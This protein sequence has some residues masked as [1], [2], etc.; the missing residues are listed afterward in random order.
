V[1][2]GRAER[3]HLES[4]VL[5]LGEALAV[6]AALWTIGWGIA[7]LTG[8]SP[9][10]QGYLIPATYIAF[11]AEV[12]GLTC[13]VASDVGARSPRSRW[14]TN[15]AARAERKRLASVATAQAQSDHLARERRE[16][17]R[18]LWW[19]QAQY[20]L[21]PNTGS[22]VLV[23]HQP[24]NPNIKVPIDATADCVVSRGAQ[25][26]KRT[27]S[28]PIPFDP[29][30]GSFFVTFPEDFEGFEPPSADNVRSQSTARIDRRR[31]PMI[32]KENKP[33]TATAPVSHRAVTG[34]ALKARATRPTTTATTMATR[35]ALM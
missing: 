24:D 17:T 18:S 20:P 16:K 31:R 15:R 30:A 4:I 6:L 19:G 10:K 21:P 8:G 35:A 13:L 29:V 28:T 3:K 12:A 14:R 26:W 23:L 22:L 27:D 5:R 11:A 7:V 9:A 25:T 34:E 32:S 2:E 1:A 33:T